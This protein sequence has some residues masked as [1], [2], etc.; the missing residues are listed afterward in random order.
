M[1][2]WILLKDEMPTVEKHGRKVLI[3]H[4][5]NAG[6]EF[7]AISLFATDKI[8]VCDKNETWWIPIP[9]LPTG[10]KLI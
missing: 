5:V 9:K 3:C 2:N 1:E 6:Q 7:E 8:H 4:T 10:H